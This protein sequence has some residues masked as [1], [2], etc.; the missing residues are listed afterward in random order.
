L[1]WTAYGALPIYLGRCLGFV[2]FAVVQP[3]SEDAR[4]A[5]ALQFNPYSPGLA[6]LFERLSY[7]WVL[8]SSFDLFGIWSLILL[9]LGARHFLR[10]TPAATAWAGVVLM[11]LWLAALTLVWRGMLAG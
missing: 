10:L 1:T 9:L 11:L 7:P 3:L 2:S 5:W 6:G 8:A 4:D